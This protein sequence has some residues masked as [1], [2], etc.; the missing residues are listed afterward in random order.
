MR[1]DLVRPAGGA[2]R[3][4]SVNPGT[5]IGGVALYSQ[6]DPFET[7]FVRHFDKL[8]ALR[9]AHPEPGLALVAI[10][11]GGALETAWLEARPG[12][13]AVATVGRHERADLHV[14]PDPGLSLRQL[15]VILEPLRGSWTDLRYR[16]I[17]LRTHAG[18]VDERGR[19][20]QALQSEGPAFV[21]CGS[22]AVL[23]L[24][25]GDDLPWPESARDAWRCLPERVYFDDVPA[26]SRRVPSRPQGL[27]RIETTIRTHAGPTA[28]ESELLGFDER[29][30]AQLRLQRA[31]AA[32]RR[33]HTVRLPGASALRR[34]VLLGRYARCD[35]TQ[36]G[37][38]LDDPMISRV[39]LLIL[40][41]GGETYAIDTASTYG[42][43]SR[44]EHVRAARLEL[45]AELALAEGAVTLR[46]VEP[47][48]HES[49]AACA[50]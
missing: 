39:H 11:L 32:D 25:T 8:R 6:H 12:R 10:G 1:D 5:V 18:L 47:E 30:V 44:G 24:P 42:T 14:G 13:V 35:V 27:A 31:S 50:C 23:C 37:H 33:Q 48:Y 7:L 29:P 15:V 2:G 26:E 34:G 36:A 28:S 4:P 20:L 49:G 21:R 22:C 40:D 43:S 9:A 46:W 38:A 45:G 41:V 16:L 17:D 19:R 3:A